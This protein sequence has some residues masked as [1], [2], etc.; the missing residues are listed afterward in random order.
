M[1][2]YFFLR[3]NM[4]RGGNL[5]TPWRKGET[6]VWKAESDY[7]RL[8]QRGYYSSPTWFDALIYA[9]G[10]IACIV[11][12]SKPTWKNIF[13]SRQ[14]SSI[15]T[16]VDFKDAAP[17]LYPFI[18]ECAERALKA[19]GISDQR[20]W[21]AIETMYKWLRGEAK[22]QDIIAAC[23]ATNDALE[24]FSARRKEYK[25]YNL[26]VAIL[27]AYEVVLQVVMRTRNPN[28]PLFMRGDH[29]GINN[30]EAI[31]NDTVEVVAATTVEPGKPG[32]KGAKAG[33][34]RW[35]RAR[36]NE[37]MEGIFK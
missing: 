7:E 10:P 32:W 11:N 3:R 33:E 13:G 36:F 12:V 14:A 6:R 15:C 24:D 8:Y 29:G 27:D 1:R 5:A 9:S 18:C 34:R 30:I 22:E 2:A 28:A 21:A 26:Y 16:L 35:Q 37:L 4:K 25:D 23:E 19:T 31:M 17:V 20:P